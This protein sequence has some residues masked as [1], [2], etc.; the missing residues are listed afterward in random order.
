MYIC[1]IIGI[2]NILSLVMHTKYFVHL[3]FVGKD[4][5]QKLTTKLSRS[6]VSLKTIL[7]LSLSSPAIWVQLL[8][9]EY[10]L[11][12]GWLSPVHGVSDEGQSLTLTDPSIVAERVGPAQLQL[13]LK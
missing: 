9:C 3:I 10:P 11:R 4:R 8:Q 2:S 6:T 13:R 1:N 5:R 7:I 12:E